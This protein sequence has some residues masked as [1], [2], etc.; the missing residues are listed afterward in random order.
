MV[1]PCGR[2]DLSSLMMKS[3]LSTLEGEVLNTGQLGKS[4]V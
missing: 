2:Q 3:T 1:T 4:Q